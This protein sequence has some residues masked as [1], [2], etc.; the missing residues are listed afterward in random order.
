MLTPINCGRLF[1]S[2]LL[3][4][5]II[6]CKTLLLKPYVKNIETVIID[7]VYNRMGSGYFETTSAPNL[8]VFSDALRCLSEVG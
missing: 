8:F 3:A 5:C 7:N 1:G 2:R 4:L 6:W